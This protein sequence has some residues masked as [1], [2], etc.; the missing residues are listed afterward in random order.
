M[1]KSYIWVLV[2]G[3]L[4]QCGDS[5]IPPQKM[6]V[7]YEAGFVEYALLDKGQPAIKAFRQHMESLQNSIVQVCNPETESQKPLFA[8]EESV[9]GELNSTEKA[10]QKTME[11]RPR[12]ITLLQDQWWQAMGAYHR[13]EV[14]FALW[15]W[16][17]KSPKSCPW[18]KPACQIYS[19]PQANTKGIRNQ[20]R[21]IRKRGDRFVH[22][23]ALGLN[24]LDALE[25]ILFSHISSTKESKP[26]REQLPCPYV[27]PMVKDLV[28][29]SEELDRAFSKKVL[30]QIGPNPT[31]RPNHRQLL[32]QIVVGL[33]FLEKGFLYQK[34]QGPL[35]LTKA[36]F[37]EE[38]KIS[39]Q[40]NIIDAI[41]HSSLTSQKSKDDLV[42]FVSEE[43]ANLVSDSKT[44]KDFESIIQDSLRRP[45]NVRP[46]YI[47]EQ[48][49]LL[50]EQWQADAEL[51]PSLA[52]PILTANS[53]GTLVGNRNTLKEL[54]KICRLRS[55]DLRVEHPFA[56]KTKEA[57]L[58]NLQFLAELVDYEW[59]VDALGA[60]RAA[61]NGSDPT[62][63]TKE[64]P[65][66]GDGA[67]AGTFAKDAD[68]VSLLNDY[69]ESEEAR[70]ASAWI[71][72]LID[73]VK[74][75]PSGG[76]PSLAVFVSELKGCTAGDLCDLQETSKELSDW[77]KGPL[78]NLLGKRAPLAVGGDID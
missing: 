59:A 73:R 9:T 65:L 76:D 42:T 21:E 22:R 14:I 38:K 7:D 15:P 55:V 64:D 3:L 70:L 77:I 54:K 69:G 19:W 17:E 51:C 53:E 34:I 66:I 60:D 26:L 67:A 57:L 43:F 5:E 13:L 63:A 29:A 39:V 47:A 56:K 45:E 16:G 28:K 44:F 49:S 35:G 23:K 33:S 52:D 12:G 10:S 58:I 50:Q 11:N 30:S 68:L 37:T 31:D 20:I 6:S 71:Q 40:S 2:L 46:D 24:G 62:N 78:V 61:S 41:T 4:I 36:S 25:F 27:V 72:D 1:I 74:T 32:E 8:E 18:S 75:M 48:V